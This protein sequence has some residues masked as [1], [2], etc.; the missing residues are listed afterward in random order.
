M[1]FN[2]QVSERSQHRSK[3]LSLNHPVQFS[4]RLSRLLQDTWSRVRET[5]TEPT[6]KGG[7]ECWAN[8]S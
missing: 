6:G 2:R 5:E 4:K 3:N 1:I 7:T 8:T